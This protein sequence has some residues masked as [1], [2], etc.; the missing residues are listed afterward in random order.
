MFGKR[1]VGIPTLLVHEGEG[2]IITVETKDGCMYRGLLKH[3]EDTMNLY[4]HNVSL[5]STKG[6]KRHLDSVWIPGFRIRFVVF[7][8]MLKHAPMFQRVVRVKK[9]ISVGT[10]LGRGRQFAI[11]SRGVYGRFFPCLLGIFFTL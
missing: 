10:G 7:P 4:L 3:A 9:G 11:E 6:E 2:L 8:D 1:T 5:T